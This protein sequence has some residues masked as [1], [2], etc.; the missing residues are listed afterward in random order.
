MFVEVGLNNEP[1]SPRQ[2]AMR[3]HSI[4]KEEISAANKRGGCINCVK[5][6]KLD[7][8]GSPGVALEVANLISGRSSAW[9]GS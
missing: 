4:G 5:N 6:L 1:A 9:H 7:E 3:G 2:D 8:R